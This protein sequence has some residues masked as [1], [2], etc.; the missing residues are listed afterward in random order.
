MM[1][2]WISALSCSLALLGCS[3]GEGDD[4]GGAGGTGGSAGTGG[5]AGVAGTGGGSGVGGSDGGAGGGSGGT[6]SGGTAGAGA[7][8]GTGGTG[9]GGAG[10]SAGAETPP[11]LTGP[12][13][14]EHFDGSIDVAATGTMDMLTRCYFPSAGQGVA[15]YP[16]L[17]LAHGF[18]IAPAKYFGSAEHV[19][20]FGYVVCLPDYPAP[21]LG[22]PDQAR[23][24]KDVLGAIDW[25]IAASGSSGS[26]LQGLVDAS[27]VAL[28]GHSAGGK[29][30]VM[31]AAQ[32]ARVR[33]LVTYD[34]VDSAS[35]CNDPVKCPD[36]SNLMPLAIPTCFLGETKDTVKLI[37]LAPSAC[38]PEADNFKTFYTPAT[39]PSLQVELLG[40]SHMSFLDDTTGC[41]PCSACQPATQARSDSLEITRAVTVAFL[42]RHLRGDERYQPYLDGA[43][44]TAR[45]VTPGKAQIQSK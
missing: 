12:F 17:V 38:A 5:G 14:V 11:W 44:A 1:S 13:A 24:A 6:G 27:R 39:A 3:S 31:G 35:F 26:P 34:P 16:L 4:S 7:A 40:A 45:W 25:A 18:Q 29:L 23:W 28:A 9:A 15:P 41:T 36:A 10:G 30:S 22:T 33:A 2:R 19:A 42:E 43:A 37:P 21:L 32:D 20:S 8:G